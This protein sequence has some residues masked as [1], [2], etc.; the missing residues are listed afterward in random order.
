MMYI[1]PEGGK[2]V[3]CIQRIVVKS[4]TQYSI[5]LAL[6]R[7]IISWKVITLTDIN[8]LIGRSVKGN[9]SKLL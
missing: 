3:M 6:L 4:R 5:A 2:V 7:E 1:D 9:V 8:F